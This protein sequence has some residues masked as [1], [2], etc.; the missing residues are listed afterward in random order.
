MTPRIRTRKGTLPHAAR[1]GGRG[2]VGSFCAGR[3]DGDPA[4]RTRMCRWVRFAP[5]ERTVIRQSARPNGPL[6]SFC[7]VDVGADIRVHSGASWCIWVHG[8]HADLGGV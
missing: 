5:L 7:A 4:A 1:P 8:E 2:A 3:A 6:G